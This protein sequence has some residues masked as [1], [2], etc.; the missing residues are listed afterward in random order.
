MEVEVVLNLVIGKIIV[1]VLLFL[2]ED[3][4][5][6]VEVVKVVFEIWFKVLVLNCLRNLYKYLQL[7]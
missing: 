3:V 6:V 7:L 5:K 1:Y 4:E 2:K